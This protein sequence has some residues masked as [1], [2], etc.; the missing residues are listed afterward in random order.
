MT[1]RNPSID[2]C[3]AAAA[4]HHIGGRAGLVEEATAAGLKHKSCGFAGL[5]APQ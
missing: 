1:V 2:P 3:D 4:A 5:C